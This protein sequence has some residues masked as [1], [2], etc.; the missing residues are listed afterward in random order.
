[1]IYLGYY[2][3]FV[4]TII[5]HLIINFNIILIIYNFILIYRYNYLIFLF[6]GKTLIQTFNL[7]WISF[8]DILLRWE[9]FFSQCSNYLNFTNSL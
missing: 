3:F 4:I 9:L 1:M 6:K 8:F 2:Y 7:K 5:N